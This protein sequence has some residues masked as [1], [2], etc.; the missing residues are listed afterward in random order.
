M[1]VLVAVRT[2]LHQTGHLHAE[3]RAQMVRLGVVAHHDLHQAGRVPQ[4]EEGHAPWS[5]RRA[6]QPAS[7]TSRPESAACSVPASSVR[8][9]APPLPR[10]AAPNQLLVSCDAALRAAGQVPNRDGVVGQIA[11]ADDD[12][13]ARP[14]RSAA[15][16]APRSPRSP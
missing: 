5:R 13:Q 12:G 9:H 6:I 2:P 10:H 14:E 16:M 7:V 8:E 15:F 11:L 1:R 4:I 3:L